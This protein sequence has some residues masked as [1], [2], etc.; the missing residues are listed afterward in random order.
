MARDDG[1]VRYTLRVPEDLYARVQ[2]AAGAKSVNA[3]IVQALEEKYPAPSLGVLWTEL[4]RALKE[5]GEDQQKAAIDLLMDNVDDEVVGSFLSKLI[6]R[7][8]GNPYR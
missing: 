4:G 3:E 6:E 7:G 5:M 8:Y 1:F 2:R